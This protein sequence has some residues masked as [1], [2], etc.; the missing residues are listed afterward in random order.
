MN[1]LK[2]KVIGQQIAGIMMENYFADMIE[3]IDKK[4]IEKE[5][6]EMKISVLKQLNNRHKNII[7]AQRVMLKEFEF[8]NNTGKEP[9]T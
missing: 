8:M 9:T 5:Q 4:E 3:K 2:E 6:C 7:D 1:A